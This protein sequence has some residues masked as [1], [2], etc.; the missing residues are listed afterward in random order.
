MNNQTNQ[1]VE[2]EVSCKTCGWFDPHNY[3]SE[4]AANVQ[5]QAHEKAKFHTGRLVIARRVRF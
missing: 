4:L 2:Y 3:K 5:G 1:E